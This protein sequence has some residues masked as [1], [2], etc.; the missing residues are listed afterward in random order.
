MK[1]CVIYR[2]QKKHKI[3][4]ASQT[5]AT[6]QSAH[7]ICQ[8]QPPT[9]YS[10]CSRFHPNRFIFGGIIA[11]R[12]NTA[13]SPRKVN[14][15]FGRYLPSSRIKIQSKTRMYYTNV[16]ITDDKRNIQFD[17]KGAGPGAHVRGNCSRGQMS[18][19]ISGGRCPRANV[20][21][22]TLIKF[23]WGPSNGAPNTGGLGKTVANFRRLS[24]QLRNRYKAMT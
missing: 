6:A 9:M 22:P 18:G 23:H 19:S 1:S 13:K 11:K 4:P 21:T 10:D 14:P 2:T 15:I 8:G 16:N 5:V 17:N 20:Q 12:M 3:S 24:C 7:K